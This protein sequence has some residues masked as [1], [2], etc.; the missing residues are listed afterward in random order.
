MGSAWER[1]IRTV[2]T[3][4]KAILRDQIVNDFHLMTVFTEAEAIVNSRPLTAV[5]DDI[6]DLEALTPNHFLLG[7]ASPCLPISI[8]YDGDSCHRKRWRYVQWLADHFWRRWKREYLPEL[9]RRNKWQRKSKSLKVGD[10]VLIK[11]TNCP[12]GSWPMARVV[13]VI[14]SEDGEVRIVK[15]KTSEGEYTR[16]N[17]KLCLLEEEEEEKDAEEETNI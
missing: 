11:D 9:T 12:R 10:L 14:E 4:L 1:M 8:V 13:E 17:A 6:D 2:K 3:A 7:R 5:S 15:I 16:P